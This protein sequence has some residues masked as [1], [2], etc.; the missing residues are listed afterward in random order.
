MSHLSLEER[1][2]SVNCPSHGPREVRN[3]K[4][5]AE[6]GKP[7]CD[8]CEKEKRLAQEQADAVARAA[9]DKSRQER[10]IRQAYDRAAIPPRFQGKAFDDFAA[11]DPQA[12]AALITC[13]DYAD[14][15]PERLRL[16]S[17]IMLCGNTGT[18]K[19]HLACAI[20]RSAIETHGK[21]AV[22]LTVG[23]AFRMVKDTYRRESRKSEEEA[24]SFFGKPDL[25]I[26]DE[27]GVQYGSDT[28]KNILFEIVN[29]RY[30]AMKPTIL[31]SNLALSALA[32]YAGDRVL[33]RMKENGGKL[34]VFDW[35]SYRGAA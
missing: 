1:T 11:G 28:E 13:R 9:E 27:V 5:F 15:F 19:T 2:E 32:E 10:M 31:I 22:Y 24:L 29:E 23:R 33:D 16:G 25:L 7:E 8:L 26:L 35:K 4:L 20:A 30:E 6:W 34:I 14:Q 18:G 3:F 12:I 21:T 17:S